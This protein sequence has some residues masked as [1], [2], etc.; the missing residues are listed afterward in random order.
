MR[1]FA[2]DIKGNIKEW[3]IT[4]IEDSTSAKISAGRLNGQLIET[5]IDHPKIDNEI[6]SRIAKKRKEGYVS[7]KDL[8]F[9]T[10]VDDFHLNNWL[11]LYLPKCN[12]D[13]NN[14]LKP[15]KCQKFSEGK[16]KYPAFAQPKLNGLRAVLRWEHWVANE[17]IFAE[18]KDGAKIRTKEGLEYVLSHIIDGLTKEWFE[19]KVNGDIAYDGELYIHGKPL[20]YIKASCPMTNSFG[21]IS[22][23]ANDPTR[24][25]FHSFDAAMPDLLQGDRLTVTMLLSSLNHPYIKRVD[26]I[27]VYSDEDVLKYRD[28]CI[29][30]GYEGCV[31]RETDAEYAFGF[32][33]SFIRK[34]KT[35]IDSEF[36]I[37]DIIPKPSDSSLP[38]FVLKNDVNDEQFECNPTGEWSDQRIMLE[39]KDDLIGKWATVR[40]RERTGTE[41]K[42]PFHSNVIG[43]RDKK[44]D[45]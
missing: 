4:L 30:L 6:A 2:R 29:K 26:E 22:R 31:V 7:L 35:H 25:E 28:D 21:T 44:G 36:L 13:A 43:I 9:T 23:S 5:I 16:I 17:G 32:R 19:T 33:P 10:I 42:L 12:T 1:L 41:K 45:G 24:V 14:N 27:V 15:M 8:N 38:L 40:Y 11:I 20:N 39:N 3:N 34:C 37:V 18:P